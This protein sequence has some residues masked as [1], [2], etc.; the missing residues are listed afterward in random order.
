MKIAS[1]PVKIFI[2]LFC[3]INLI[4]CRKENEEFTE[5][6]DEET[7]KVNSKLSNLLL[8]TTLNDGSKDNILDNTSCFSISLPVTINLNEMRLTINSEDDFSI[9]EDSFNE[10]DD[11]NG[12]LE[13]VYPIAI[14][15]SNHEEIAIVNNKELKKKIKECRKSDPESG[16][17]D[18]EC[19]DFKYPIAVSVFDADRELIKIIT[20]NNDKNLFNFIKRLDQYDRANIV[21]PVTVQLYDNSEIVIN[22]ADELENILKNVA[23]ECEDEN[24]LDREDF[25]SILTGS[26]WSIQK[27]KDDES[28]ETEEFTS[29]TYDFKE[30]EVIVASTKNEEITGSW[31]VVTRVDGGLYLI[32]N[33]AD[34]TPLNKLNKK[35]ILKSAKNKKIKL[36]SLVDNEKSKDELFFRQ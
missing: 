35:W 28:N 15:N 16:D 26:T 2:F 5:T 18:I 4:S 32:I 17:E 14:I 25:I 6:K 31:T 9:I 1:N 22:T 36:E 19:I 13:F 20:L 11:D 33:F 3:T 23:D 7:L 30:N 27:F 29:F 10:F 21:F 34:K 24:D 12:S 8:K